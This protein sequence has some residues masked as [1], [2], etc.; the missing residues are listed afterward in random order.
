M[1]HSNKTQEFTEAEAQ[2]ILT[3]IKKPEVA[4]AAGD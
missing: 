2:A 1:N 4:H 3:Q